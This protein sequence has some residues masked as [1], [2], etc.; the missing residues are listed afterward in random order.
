[1]RKLANL[2]PIKRNVDSLEKDNDEENPADLN[3]QAD[4]EKI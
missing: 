3:Q 4:T 2:D 1:M